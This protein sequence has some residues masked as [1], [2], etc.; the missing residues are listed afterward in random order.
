MRHYQALLL[1]SPSEARPLT[2]DIILMSGAQI[3]GML[4][5]MSSPVKVF[6]DHDVIGFRIPRLF[7]LYFEVGIYVLYFIESFRSF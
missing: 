3:P 1:P 4:I 2:R 5:L 7:T 6:L